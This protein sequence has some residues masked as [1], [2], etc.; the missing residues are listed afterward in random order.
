MVPHVWFRGLAAKKLLADRYLAPPMSQALAPKFGYLNAAFDWAA[1]FLVDY[2]HV[3]SP[4]LRSVT[5]GAGWGRFSAAPHP[6]PPQ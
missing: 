2:S 6:T 1:S 4:L 5:V 3:D